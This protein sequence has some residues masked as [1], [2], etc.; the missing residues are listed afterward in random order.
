[1]KSRLLTIIAVTVVLTSCGVKKKAVG[2]VAE[3]SPAPTWHTCLIQ[4]TR[5]TVDKDGERVSA[6]VLMQ[7]VRDSLLVISV[8][9]M[10]GMEMMR[11]EAT[12]LEVTAIDKLHGTYA[13]ASFADINRKLTPSL[14]WDILQQICSAEL[15]EGAKRARLTYEFG[16]EHIEIVLD[17]GVRQTDVPVRVTNQRLNNYTPI[18]ISK[19]L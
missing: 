18:D 17:Y 7:T 3:S 6:N 8:M 12:P 15:P 1:V 10:F 13:Q 4:G 14:N 11:L 2:P 5:V 19:W 16:E 9:P